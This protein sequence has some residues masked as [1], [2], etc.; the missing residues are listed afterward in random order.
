MSLISVGSLA[1]DGIRTVAGEK[2]RILG[3]SLTHFSNAASL[4]SK[5]S[6]VG[7]VGEDFAPAEWDFLKSKS[8]SI[9]GVEVLSGEKTFFWKGY[10]TEDF[11]I[12]IT[13]E[14]QLNALAK[15]DPKVP[16]SYKKTPY[17]LFLANMVP[18]LQSK[19][20]LQCPGSVLKVLDTM[21]FWIENNAPGLAQAFKDVDGIIVNEGEAELLTGQ[22]NLI[23]AAEMLFQPHFKILILKKGS[24]GV[25]VFTRDYMISLPAY[26][27]KE[28]VDPTGAGDSFAGAFFSY[29]DAESQGGLDQDTVKQAAAYAT[30]VA[31]FAVEDFGVNGINNVSPAQVQAR[32]DDFRKIVSF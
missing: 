31:S 3:G 30:V 5:P 1:Y 24:H 2:P 15:F 27:V 29:L 17:I 7:V 23:K 11:D 10:Y 32:L 26:P 25:M 28:I 13:E 9:E 12:A 22:K 20:A 19:A 8:H 14:T 4:K 18:E 6:L 16:E 21:N